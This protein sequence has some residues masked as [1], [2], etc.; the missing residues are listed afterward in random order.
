M[1]RATS[2]KEDPTIAYGDFDD[3]GRKDV[4]LLIETA[5]Q[6]GSIKIVAC[7][8][9]IGVTKPIVVQKPYC[10]DGIT[11]ISKGQRYHNFTTERDG[12]YPKDGIHAYYFRRLA[13]PTSLPPVL[14]ARLLT[15]T[16]TAQPYPRR[17]AAW[18]SAPPAA[19]SS[20][21]SQTDQRVVVQTELGPSNDNLTIRI[22]DTCGVGEAGPRGP[23]GE[24]GRE[25]GGQ[26]EVVVHGA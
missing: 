2:R 4:A 19:P 16:E 1:N 12:T 14:F 7:L 24:A 9:S 26:R 8:S 13:L 11:R 21:A 10:T 5:P 22:S 18:P 17:V 20:L 3:D 6:S 23:L 15:A 25:L